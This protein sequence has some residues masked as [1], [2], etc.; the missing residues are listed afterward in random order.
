MTTWKRPWLALMVFAWNTLGA[1]VPGPLPNDTAPV[2]WADY[3][4]M[5]IKDLPQATSAEA[6][7]GHLDEQR[8]VAFLDDTSLKWTRQNQCAT[9]HTNVPYLMVRPLLHG[10]DT[11]AMQEVR[12]TVKAFAAKQMRKPAADATF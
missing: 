11:A 2:D 4:K 12:T 8:A 6:V 3:E 9:C 1:Q 10:G 5:W 7:L